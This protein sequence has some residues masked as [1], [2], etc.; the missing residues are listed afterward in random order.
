MVI[1]ALLEAD[2]LKL[3]DEIPG[4]RSARKVATFLPLKS[5]S[6]LMP[7]EPRAG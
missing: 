2:G 6:E 7:D 1:V 4:R 3:P 5:F